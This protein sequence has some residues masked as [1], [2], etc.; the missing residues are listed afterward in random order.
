M[1]TSTQNPNH[2]YLGAQILYQKVS[3]ELNSLSLALKHELREFVFARLADPSNNTSA[4]IDKLASTGALLGC[5]GVVEGWPNF[6][7]DLL[8]FMEKS[9]HHLR[10]GIFVLERTP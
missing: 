1:V 8:G 9:A 7:Q 10:S 2:Q 6:V 3:A 4:V 5:V